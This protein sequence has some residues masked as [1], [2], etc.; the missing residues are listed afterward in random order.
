M[1]RL[2]WSDWIPPFP[3]PL[4]RIMEWIGFVSFLIGIVKALRNLEVLV[5]HSWMVVAL[6]LMFVGILSNN[7]RIGA[8]GLIQIFKACFWVLRKE[9][10][11]IGG[12]STL[13]QIIENGR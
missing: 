2:S 8:N 13:F 7:H 4:S 3:E 5:V 11:A 6:T 12:F 9:P 1:S 10:K